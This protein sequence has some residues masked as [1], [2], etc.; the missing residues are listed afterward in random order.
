[1]KIFCISD[2]Q[3]LEVGLK[4]AGCD[5]I[6]CEK[7]DEVR[8]KIDEIVE[9]KEYGILVITKTIYE[10]AKEKIDNLRQTT[11]LPLI[12]II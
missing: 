11:K 4:L 9:N 6:T 1:M 12:T 2:F 8:K 7:E 5:G 3:E 10:K